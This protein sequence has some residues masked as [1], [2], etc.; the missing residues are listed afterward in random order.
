MKQRSHVTF[1][2]LGTA[3]AITGIVVAVAITNRTVHLVVDGILFI[4]LCGLLAAYL[5]LSRSRRP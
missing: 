5:R 2:L 4:G 1:G 3:I